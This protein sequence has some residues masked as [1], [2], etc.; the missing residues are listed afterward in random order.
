MGFVRPQEENGFSDP[1]GD[2]LGTAA[3]GGG[4]RQ[5]DGRVRRGSHCTDGETPL[6][7][8][9]LGGVQG[10]GG[11]VW[12]SQ[13]RRERGCCHLEQGPLCLQ[14][15]R[16]SG[17]GLSSAG[18]Y[19]CVPSRCHLPIVPNPPGVIV[20]LSHTWPH[21]DISLHPLASRFLPCPHIPFVPRPP[22][23]PYPHSCHIPCA[24]TPSQPPCPSFCPSV[25]CVPDPSMSPTHPHV[26]APCTSPV[27]ISPSRPHIPLSPIVPSAPR[28]PVSPQPPLCPL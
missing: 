23:T 7:V 18:P 12:V 21:R 2:T 17:I 19:P 6:R 4:Q 26:P 22:T 15:A 27:P 11:D 5:R 9:L 8:V 13:H 28:T 20:S 14:P 10:R 16:S 25:P 24:P 3:I 1:P